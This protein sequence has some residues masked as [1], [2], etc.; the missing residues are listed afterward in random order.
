MP[1][2]RAALATNELGPGVSTSLG[3]R[4]TKAKVLPAPPK[5]PKNKITGFPIEVGKSEERYSVLWGPEEGG[6]PPV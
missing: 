6:D 3:L 4:I 1:L 2:L 5:R